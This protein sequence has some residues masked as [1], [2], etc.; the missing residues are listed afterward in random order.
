MS[1]GMF[2]PVGELTCVIR[3]HLPEGVHSGLACRRHQVRRSHAHAFGACKVEFLVNASL[4]EHHKWRMSRPKT[5]RFALAA[6]QYTSARLECS[7]QCTP[8]IIMLHHASSIG[9]KRLTNI[10]VVRLKRNGERFEI[11]CY[12]NKVG[13]WRSEM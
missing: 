5:G 9:Q 13:D 2:Q 12:K 1:R 4:R 3:G 6:Q 8:W 7:R 11:A 10:A